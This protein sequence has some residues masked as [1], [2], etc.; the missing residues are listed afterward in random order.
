MQAL[1]LNLRQPC[2]QSNADGKAAP[3]IPHLVA[4]LDV[5]QVRFAGRANVH[6]LMGVVF[7][8][9]GGEVWGREEGVVIA[10]HVPEHIVLQ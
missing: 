8:Q 4:E 10:H 5:L 7:G 9:D 2:R 6:H 3:P 1:V